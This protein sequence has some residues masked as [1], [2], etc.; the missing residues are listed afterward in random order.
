MG[1]RKTLKVYIFVIEHG[2]DIIPVSFYSLNSQ[3]SF[4]T[5]HLI[6]I[7][8]RNIFS[9]KVEIR[10]LNTLLIPRGQKVKSE[11]APDLKVTFMVYANHVPSFMFLSQSAQRNCLAAL[12]Y[13]YHVFRLH[14]GN[15]IIL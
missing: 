12:L 7:H 6:F 2:T 1:T 13:C 14:T 15:N 3:L 10:L 11:V 5:Q 4:D 9:R 8:C